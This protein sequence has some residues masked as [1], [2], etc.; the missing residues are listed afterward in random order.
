MR[1]L[2]LLS[3]I[4][5]RTNGDIL[6]DMRELLRGNAALWRLRGVVALTERLP[7]EARKQKRE[8]RRD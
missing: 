7:I 8:H 1:R 5:I 3:I 2:E 4:A 6:C